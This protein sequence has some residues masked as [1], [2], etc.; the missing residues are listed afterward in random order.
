MVNVIHCIYCRY[1]DISWFWRVLVIWIGQKS[2]F[3][4]KI[5]PELFI[6]DRLMMI[7]C[8][9]SF[10]MMRCL[11]S[12]QHLRECLTSTRSM[13]KVDYTFIH[14]IYLE[15]TRTCKMFQAWRHKYLG[16]HGKK[17]N[18]CSYLSLGFNA[19]IYAS[20]CMFC[21]PLSATASDQ[22]SLCCH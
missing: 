13:G 8:D 3:Y 19:S 16:D 6:T 5:F 9:K 7:D 4:K 20:V 17:N 22:S 10:V 12:D 21:R 11:N 1:I 18:L 15:C 2:I 14:C